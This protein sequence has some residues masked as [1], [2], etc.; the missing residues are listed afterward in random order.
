MAEVR[1]VG[2]RGIHLPAQ[3]RLNTQPVV[4]SDNFI[5]TYTTAPSQATLDASTLDLGA[6]ENE[7]PVVPAYD[8]AG[9]NQSFITAY[10]PWA[11]STYHGLA[12]QVNKRFSHGLQLVGA[13]TYSHH[14][15]DATAEV[16]STVWRRAARKMA[17]I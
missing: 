13:Y 16:F 2:T 10:E 14:I 9:F 4:T 6:L 17:W 12:A 15:D 11:S 1:Y 8:A 3:I 7:R 5:P